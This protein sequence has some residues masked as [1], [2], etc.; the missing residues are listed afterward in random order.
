M[1]LVSLACVTSW[2]SHIH[3]YSVLCK[4]LTFMHELVPFNLYY[5]LFHIPIF[6]FNFKFFGI[7]KNWWKEGRHFNRR[8]ELKDEEK[9]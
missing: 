1:L 5:L 4:L 6:C 2:H 7:K 3:T 9:K 8:H